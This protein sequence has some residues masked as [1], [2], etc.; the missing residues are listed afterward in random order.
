MACLSL[1]GKALAWLAQREHSRLE[2]QQKLERYARKVQASVEDIAPLLD[3]LQAAGHLSEARFV[4][5]RVHARLSRFGNRR[6]EQELRAKGVVPEE[7]LRAQLRNSELMRAQRVFEAKFGRSG[8]ASPDESYNA[9]S[10][11]TSKPS[12]QLR[13]RQARFLAARGFS[14]ATVAQ[15]LKGAGVD[16]DAPE[17]GT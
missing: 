2:L 1:R 8:D 7:T 6:I 9:P 5:S 4:E 11:A 10:E 17:E 14:A 13:A 3:A 12:L 15:V 16:E